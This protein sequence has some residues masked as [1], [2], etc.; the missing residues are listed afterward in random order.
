M[1]TTECL[2]AKLKIIAVGNVWQ[3]NGKNTPKNAFQWRV[4]QRTCKTKPRLGEAYIDRIF[5]FLR[6]KDHA[7]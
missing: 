7:I 2:Q 3:E 6:F 4:F 1:K 5:K